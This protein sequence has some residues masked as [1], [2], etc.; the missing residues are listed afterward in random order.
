VIH[1]PQVLLKSP[2]DVIVIPTQWRARDIAL[3]ITR[4]GIACEQ[5]LLEYQGKLVDFERDVHPYRL[6]PTEQ[7]NEKRA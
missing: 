1:T 3:E 2:V 5:L 4:R 6:T 7:R